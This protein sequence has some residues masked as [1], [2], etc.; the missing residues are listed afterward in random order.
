MGAGTPDKEVVAKAKEIEVYILG[1]SKL[2]EIPETENAK[3]F[4]NILTAALNSS[5]G[6]SCPVT[7]TQAIEAEELKTAAQKTA[8]KEKTMMEA[9]KIGK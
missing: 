2:P 4:M 9:E 7:S 3:D 5:M 1:E 8:K 6:C